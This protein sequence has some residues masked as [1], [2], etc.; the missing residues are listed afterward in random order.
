MKHSIDLKP[1]DPKL[2]RLETDPNLFTFETTDQIKDLTEFVG[3]SRAVEATLFGI[4][5]DSRGYNLYAMGSSGVGKHTVIRSILEA[6]SKLE[7]VPSDWCYVN[8]F[9]NPQKP[10]AIELKPGSASKFRKDMETL[11]EDLSVSM[12]IIFESDEYRARMQSLTDDINEK[13]ENLFKEIAEDAKKENVVIV[14]TNQGFSVLPVNEQGEVIS[15]EDFRKLSEDLRETKEATISKFGK[16]ITE[17]MSKTVRLNNKRKKKE[18]ELKKE[19]AILSLT[20]Y[21]EN[22][23]KKYHDVPEILIYMDAFQQD[24]INNYKDFVKHDEE[25]NKIMMVIEKSNLSRYK[26]NVLVDHSGEKG[27][28]VIYE[29]HPSYQNLVCRVEHVV[30]FGALLTDFTLIKAGSLHKANGGYLMVDAVKLLQHPYAWAGLKRALFTRK[31]TVEPPERMMGFLNTLSLDPMPIPLDIKI[32]LLG[33]R[34]TYYMLSTLDPDFPELFKVAVDFEE[35]IDR[36]QEHQELYARLIGTISRR[37]G[38]R[39]YHRA[40]VAAIIDQTVRLAHDT[41]KLSAHMR[42]INDLVRESDFWAGKSGKTMVEQADVHQAIKAQIHRVDRMRTYYYELITRD[43]IFIETEGEKVGQ[44]NALSTVDY[45]NFCFGHPSKITARIR[46]GRDGVIDIQR[47]VKM[48][49]PI[50]SKGVLILSGFLAGRYV[51][52]QPFSLSATLVFEQTYSMVEGDSA[53]VAELAALLS[54]FSN[55]PIKQCLAVTGSINQH[56]DVQAVGGI[57][58]KIEGFFDICNARRLTGEQ[59]VIIPTANLSSLMLR[60]D[61]VTAVKQGLFHIYAIQN[62]DEAVTLLTGVNAGTRNKS[63]KF[64]AKSINALA[65]ICLFKFAKKKARPRKIRPHK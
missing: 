14:S 25:T 41:E 32:V 40:A 3:Q 28:P 20:P 35:I 8:N 39:P 63:G 10:I 38:L 30:Q 46:Y 27:A 58:E 50:H 16:R 13:Q 49:G 21:I 18:Q 15:Q 37:E 44:V 33:D 11:I 62:V 29:D 53:S 43:I 7:K 48:G 56:G 4:G 36:T 2:L 51:K 55:M 54:A 17:F 52:D 61:V 65:E 64:P 1:I 59:G 19:F 12:P 22:F 34:L 57:N 24:V 26:V 47:E 31:I 23:K 6:E 9:E 5:I 45:G 42:S 60:E